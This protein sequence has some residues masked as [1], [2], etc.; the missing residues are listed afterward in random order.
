M[1]HA[2]STLRSLFLAFLCVA[3]CAV[4]AQ[5]QD[6]TFVRDLSQRITLRF[7]GSHKFNSMLVKADGGATD[8]R[9]RPNGQINFGIGASLRKLTL[10][11]GVRMPFVNNDEDRKGH[12]RY[13]DAQANLY[14]TKQATNLFLQVFKGYHITS[15]TKEMLGWTGSTELPYRP[16]VLQYN[17]GVSSL[18]IV[19]HERFSYRA[20]FNQDAVQLKSQGSWL[21]GG[22]LTGF[23]VRS[24]SALVPIRY[25]A[26]FSRTGTVQGASFYDLGPMVGYAYTHVMGEKWF[27]TVSGAVGAGAAVQVLR[28]AYNDGLRPTTYFSSGWH[29]QVRA[30]AGYNTRLRYIGVVFS[31]EHVGYW[32]GGQQRFVWDVGVVRVVFAQ[33]FKE[34]PKVMDKGTKWLEQEK[35]KVLPTP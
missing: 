32:L 20:G 22:Y 34:R 9:Y 28:R 2:E 8:L 11:I 19:N 16:D 25:R 4:K 35:D 6:A 5:Q 31:Q 29:T 30:A 3:G 23:V 7:Y 1:H 27:A 24:D 18:R 14:G 12:T 13:L 33:R 26:D 21:V 10:N 15:H 17:F